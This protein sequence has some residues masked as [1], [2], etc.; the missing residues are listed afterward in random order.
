MVFVT[1]PKKVNASLWPFI[2]IPAGRKKTTHVQTRHYHVDRTATLEKDEE[3]IR[4][5]YEELLQLEPAA[6][7]EARKTRRRKKS[8]VKS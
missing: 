4:Q 2:L 1:V 3:E 6:F 7:S 8:N 5:L